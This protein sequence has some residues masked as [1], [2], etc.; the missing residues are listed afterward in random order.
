M[1]KRNLA[2]VLVVSVV[3]GVAAFAWAEGGPSRP[4]LA[5]A[6]VTGPDRA[7]GR[8]PCGPRGPGR[9]AMGGPGA[10]HRAIH[11][12]LIVPGQQGF[13]NVSFDRGALT[14]ASA[15]SVTVQRPD[16]TSVTKSVDQSTRFR[17]VKA[18]TDLQTGAPALVVSKG[19][20]AIA[21][22]QPRR[23][24]ADGSGPTPGACAGNRRGGPGVHMGA[25]QTPAV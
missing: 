20:V 4:R 17:G 9:G 16:G 3:L 12:D 24:A 14:A 2:V 15:S 22:F 25:D 21:V 7:P 11:G 8:R 19:D 6:T 5:T 23:A 13:Q 10:L 1:L 18:A